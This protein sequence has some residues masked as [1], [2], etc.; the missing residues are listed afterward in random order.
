MLCVV[1]I[2][3][4]PGAMAICQ[5]CG[6]KSQDLMK[7]ESCNRRFTSST[8]YFVLKKTDGPPEGA[9]KSDPKRRKLDTVG[10]TSGIDK[11]N[12]YN[13]KIKEQ[14]AVYVQV[15]SLNTSMKGTKVIRGHV[16]PL[17]G[18]R[19]RGRGRGLHGPPGKN[20]LLYHENILCNQL[21][22]F[23]NGCVAFKVFIM[24]DMMKTR[25]TI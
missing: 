3:Q 11:K 12:F 1:T 10:E 15:V 16:R 9:Q 20:S 23:R 2:V 5:W 21:L 14:N 19:G 4:D 22:I 25:E 13:S 17:R 18:Q 6:T 24:Y 8:K 7:C